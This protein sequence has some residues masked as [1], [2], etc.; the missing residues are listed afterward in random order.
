V[1]DSRARIWFSLFVLAV[2]CLGGAG[3]FLLGR[4]LPPAP[5]GREFAPFASYPTCSSMRHNRIS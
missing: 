2:F 1:S 3:G 4:R 5:R